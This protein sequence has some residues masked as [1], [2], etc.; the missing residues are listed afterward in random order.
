MG[1][2][3]AN[4]KTEDDIKDLCDILLHTLKPL[5]H[6]NANNSGRKL[7]DA[8]VH[9]GAEVA[10]NEIDENLGA[11]V[12]LEKVETNLRVE[13]KALLKAKQVL[14]K[15]AAKKESSPAVTTNRYRNNE[16]THPK[17]SAKKLNL[18]WHS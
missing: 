2:E 5:S 8:P 9:M 1:G 12:W 18:V 3:V 4:E 7:L 10:K 15:K 16:A 13:S 17:Y 14:A 6:G 11:N